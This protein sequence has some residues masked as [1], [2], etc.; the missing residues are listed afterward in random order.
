MWLCFYEADE[1]L[2]II[3]E[4]RQKL[5]TSCGYKLFFGNQDVT[6]SHVNFH[7]YIHPVHSRT[8]IGVIKVLSGKL[9]TTWDA[10]MLRPTI[11]NTHSNIW[12]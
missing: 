1:G 4:G 7:R 5:T 10:N 3:L 12:L 9:F 6:Q 11:W 2:F 8:C